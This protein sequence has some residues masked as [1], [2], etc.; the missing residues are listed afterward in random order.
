MMRVFYLDGFFLVIL[1]EN[2]RK[3]CI[4]GKKFYLLQYKLSNIHYYYEEVISRR[5]GV[6]GLDTSD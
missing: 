6:N 4:F 1:C 3:S 2:S 5:I